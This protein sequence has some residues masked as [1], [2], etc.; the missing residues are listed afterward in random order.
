MSGGEVFIPGL[1]SAPGQPQDAG[2]EAAPAA[3][4]PRLTGGTRK[5]STKSKRRWDISIEA[6]ILE[7]VARIYGY[8]N[9]PT[10]LPVV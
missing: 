4:P 1:M 5:S 7:E 10:T 8:D 6:D 9:L 3:R 2:D